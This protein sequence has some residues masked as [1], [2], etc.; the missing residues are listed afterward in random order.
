[1][2][3][4]LFDTPVTESIKDNHKAKPLYVF[5]LD[6]EQVS[7][8]RQLKLPDSALVAYAAITAAAYGDRAN[9]WVTLSPRTMDSVGRGFRWWHNATSALER[10][11]LIEVQRHPG[12]LP[13]YKLK[14][15]DN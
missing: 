14:R 9:S 15:R 13:R 10:V 8:V 11:G 5:R 3:A 12:R 2:Q 6:E 1:M 4:D 7:N